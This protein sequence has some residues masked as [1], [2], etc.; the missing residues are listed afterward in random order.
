MSKQNGQ[1]HLVAGREG[2]DTRGSYG[3]MLSRPDI[4]K[5]LETKG[6]NLSIEGPETKNSGQDL[7]NENKSKNKELRVKS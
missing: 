5:K 2:R 1:N 7:R 6:L 3:A 4:S